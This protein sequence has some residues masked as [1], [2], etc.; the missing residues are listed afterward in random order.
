MN[1]YQPYPYRDHHMMD[2]IKQYMIVEP[3]VIQ[4]LNSLRSKEVIIETTR[5][6]IRG[7]VLDVKPDHVVLM[8]GDSQFFMR[9]CE[10]IWIMP[11]S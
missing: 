8:A 10:I 2:K 5:G 4:A 11:E 9:I 3:Y 1:Y 6:S 7:V